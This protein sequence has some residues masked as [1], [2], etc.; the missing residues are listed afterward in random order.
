M[1]ARMAWTR[2]TWLALFSTVVLYVYI[3][4]TVVCCAEEP[5]LAKGEAVFKAQCAS[6]HGID[7]QGTRDKYNE[8]L[9]GDLSITELAKVIDET[10]PEGEPEKCSAA[11]SAAVAAFIHQAF[12]SEVARE[13]LRP[14]RIELARLTVAQYRNAVADLFTTDRASHVYSAAHGLRGEYFDGR[15]QKRDKRVIERVDRR[16]DFDWGAG[17]PDDENF[18]D[19]SMVVRWD[20]SI[21]PP[22]T[23][24][25]DFCVETE[26]A[27]R[28]WINDDRTALID[29]W[30]RSGNDRQFRG[31]RFLIGGRAYPIRLEYLNASELTAS[32][33]LKWKPPHD[34][35]QVIASHHLRASR[36][37]ESIAV[38]TQFPPD[39]SSAGY[40]RGNA[41][42]KE[43]DQA[44]TDAALSVAD[45]VVARLG[46]L[47]G[48][49]PEDGN[50]T[51]KL[52]EYAA[53]M[54]AQAWGRPV[55][56]H[57]KELFIDRFFS[58][59]PTPEQAIKRVVLLGLK[60]PNFLF[61]E[62]GPARSRDYANASRLS[63][64]LWDSI[65]DRELT[66]AAAAG[67][68]H[69]E[70]HVVAQATRMVDDPR[71]RAKVDEFM[72]HW[73]K[74]DAEID[75]SKDPQTLPEFTPEVISDLQ[76]SLEL[77]LNNVVWSESSDFRQ[78]IRADYILM[79]RRLAE[80][81]AP[82]YAKAQGDRIADFDFE[83]VKV[84][85][86]DNRSGV[87]T[88]PFL[89]SM[90]AYNRTSSPIHRGVFLARSM[91]GRAIKSPP[92][93]ITPIAPDLHADLTT[94]ERVALQTSSAFCQSCHSMINSLGFGLEQYDVIGRIRSEEKGKAIDANGTYRDRLGKLVS[95]N[96][97]SEL[98][99]FL[100]DS[101]EVQTAFVGQLFQ[102][103]VKQ[104]PAAFGPET[105]P[106]LRDRFA[107]NNFNIRKLIIDIARVSALRGVEL[108]PEG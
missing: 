66:K 48:T 93:A 70:Q 8:P 43:W 95:F 42:S 59:S 24:M 14:A 39:D 76:K 80:L 49:K 22:S 54:L 101:Q 81:Y 78:L 86:G 77:F 57:E 99:A 19:V 83:F 89:M 55:T 45:A 26:N 103:L 96:G 91:L 5:D 58:S 25:Y 35:E 32:I 94:R 3:C 97:S 38:A 4:R 29:A 104:P 60:S 16:I 88:H 53:N 34:I 33:K 30:V 27:T 40:A 105:L 52:K 23:G 51:D 36:A 67:L 92:V 44:T 62:I 72:R 2:A 17:T 15:S 9:A 74:L 21:I 56:A 84:P 37:P 41:I 106:G 63:F 18:R 61:R 31:S 85:S 64:T 75:I 47:S 7:G 102:H 65:P 71:T 6:C 100:V 11:E 50:R 87:V 79:N 69:D 28:L 13:R 68:M 98:A 10:M 107:Q 12:Y 82:E 108:H 73:L 90:F 1:P 46:Q 20:G